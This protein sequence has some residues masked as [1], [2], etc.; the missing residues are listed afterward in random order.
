MQ[1]SQPPTLNP[2]SV[3][4]EQLL[5]KLTPAVRF[6]LYLKMADHAFSSERR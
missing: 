1:R 4:H 6:Y 5:L 3:I 2:S